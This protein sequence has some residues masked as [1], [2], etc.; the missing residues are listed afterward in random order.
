M[1]FRDAALKILEE[2]KKPL[3]YKKIATISLEQNLLDYIGSNPTK[4]ML[5]V[6]KIEVKKLNTNVVLVKPGFFVLKDYYPKAIKEISQFSETEKKLFE[7]NKQNDTETSNSLKE[8]FKN[9]SEIS[10][11]IY[12][13]KYFTNK[14]EIKPEIKS[15]IQKEVQ[16]EIKVEV[17]QEVKQESHFQ[18]VNKFDIPEFLI[19]YINKKT[20]IKYYTLQD[21]YDILKQE[22]I[23]DISLIKS[24]EIGTLIKNFNKTKLQK[25][26]KE[27]F[28]INGTQYAIL[29][30]FQSNELTSLDFTITEQLKERDFVIKKDLHKWL[31]KLSL[32]QFSSFL[33]L[34]IE[35]LD[36]TNFEKIEN[37]PGYYT[38]A[39]KIGL[40]K[41]K[42]VL[43]LKRQNNNVTK[44]DII[45]FR[46]MLPRFNLTNGI[47]LTTSFFDDSA[48]EEANL[49]NNSNILLID[50][51][52]II[53]L[54]LSSSIGVKDGLFNQK[55]ID[56]NFFLSLK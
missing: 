8:T 7:F 29:D 31:Q 15:E 44:H 54:M 23:F 2:Q 5:D 45:E 12:N 13:E 4:R 9:I 11:Q 25:E 24:S 39:K 17:K 35:K 32:E 21:F 50:K 28:F 52:F 41:L 14:A 51:T 42:F 56:H 38:I 36:F 10:K 19:K 47:L 37:F 48:I 1:N 20:E 27:P 34:F 33:N 49:T 16:K 55:K 22:N 53:D 30:S 43:F 26:K 6:L 3:H 40:S 18:T 46:G